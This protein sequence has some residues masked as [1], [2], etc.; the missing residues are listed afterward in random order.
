[1]PGKKHGPNRLFGYL[2]THNAVMQ[3]LL[4]GD[5]V[6]KDGISIR[7]FGN[8]FFLMSGTVECQGPISL[9][10][11]KFLGIVDRTGPLVQT[12]EYSYNAALQGIGNILRYDSP[13]PTHNQY[14]HV[15]RYDVLNNSAEKVEPIGDDDWPTLGKVIEELSDWYYGNYEAIRAKLSD[16]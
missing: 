12:V 16:S 11:E 13:H 9:E 3:R 2:E 7:S 4:L 6:L 14:H 10:V 15:H 5:F 1:M 8:G